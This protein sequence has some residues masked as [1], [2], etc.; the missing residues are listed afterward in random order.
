MFEV[1]T[2]LTVSGITCTR[3]N[4][5]WFI[6]EYRC[7]SCSLSIITLY[8]VEDCGRLEVDEVFPIFYYLY[9]SLIKS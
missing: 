9:Y 4:W 5:S 2:S 1:L 8:S 3:S 7:G 6:W